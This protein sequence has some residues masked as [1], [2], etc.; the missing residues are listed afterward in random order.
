MPSTGDSAASSATLSL[1]E[2][3]GAAVSL[4]L[5]KDSESICS[6]PE[7]LEESWE[8]VAAL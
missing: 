1:L 6:K 4:Y 5:V 2:H 7:V 3:Q 8:R